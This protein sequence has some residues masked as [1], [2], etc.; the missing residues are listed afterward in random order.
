LFD[1]ATIQLNTEIDRVA[2]NILQ[3]FR[4]EGKCHIVNAYQLQKYCT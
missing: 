1:L 4:V 2:A 3:T